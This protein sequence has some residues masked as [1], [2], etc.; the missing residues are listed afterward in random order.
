MLWLLEIILHLCG[1]FSHVI[2][3]KLTFYIEDGLQ[4]PSLRCSRW[5]W[6]N[7]SRTSAPPHLPLHAESCQPQP[8]TL[9]GQCRQRSRRHLGPRPKGSTRLQMTY[10]DAVHTLH[11]G[12]LYFKMSYGFI[13][14]V[15]MQLY[16]CPW[17]KYGFWN[18]QIINGFTWRPFIMNFTEIGQEI[19]TVRIE[20]RIICNC[21]W[22]GW[23]KLALCR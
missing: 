21:H 17:Q 19:W 6:L 22:P 4:H 11:R 14:H 8:D 7:W 12:V 23:R 15:S 5:F 2:G 20:M 18:S 3:S 13:A 16:K 10:R 9:Q 1:W